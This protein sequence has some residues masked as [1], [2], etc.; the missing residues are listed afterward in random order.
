MPDLTNWLSLICGWPEVR[1]YIARHPSA[2]I[3]VIAHGNSA[4]RVYLPT[5]EA[6][7]DFIK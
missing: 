2:R 3:V 1:H 4:V 5:K 6:M 7:T